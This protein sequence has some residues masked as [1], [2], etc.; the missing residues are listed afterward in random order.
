MSG[1]L[2][3]VGRLPL[4]GE[5][6]RWIE[7]CLAYDWYRDNGRGMTSPGYRARDPFERAGAAIGFILASAQDP[8]IECHRQLDSSFENGDA[9]EV[10]HWL[11]VLSEEVPAWR[12]PLR[13]W[14]GPHGW[15]DWEQAAR[16]AAAHALPL[17]REDGPRYETY[18]QPNGCWG[19][20]DRHLA[21]ECTIVAAGMTRQ[22]AETQ[23]DRLARRHA[24]G[25]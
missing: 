4:S 14:A 2:L 8:R 7:M 17:F 1:A 22:D 6:L 5:R 3:R 11:I 21:P 24:C 16:T 10:C 13:R 15:E 19:V 18:Q 9:D 12:E 23:R 20:K 25:I